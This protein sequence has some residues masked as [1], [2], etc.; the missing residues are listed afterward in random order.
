ML[1]NINPVKSIEQARNEII[2]L[3]IRQKSGSLDDLKPFMPEIEK[4]LSHLDYRQ[5]WR[6]LPV[7]A[8]VAMI[9]SAGGPQHFREDVVLPNTK[10]DLELVIKMLNYIREQKKLSPVKMPLFVQPDEIELARKEGKF[11][12]D[13]RDITSQIS[14]IFQRGAIMYVGFVFGRNYAILQ[15]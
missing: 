15:A 7:V 2:R 14:I 6:K 12:S 11:S 5:E 1:F 13:G 10:H 4:L 3:V 9:E 8:R